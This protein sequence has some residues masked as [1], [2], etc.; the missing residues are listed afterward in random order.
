MVRNKKQ[1]ISVILSFV[2]V[3]GIEAKDPIASIPFSA[4]KVNWGLKFGNTGDNFYHVFIEPDT[5]Y[6]GGLN[7]MSEDLRPCIYWPMALKTLNISDAPNINDNTLI[8]DVLEHQENIEEL[9]LTQVSIS[10]K[11][12]L[13]I[14]KL[15][16]LKRLHL[17]KINFVTWLGIYHLVQNEKIL[18]TLEELTI[19]G[20][21][22]G[23]SGNQSDYT[24]DQGNKI[25]EIYYEY[26]GLAILNKFKNLRRLIIRGDTSF[27][28][29]GN[30]GR[31]M[32]KSLSHLNKLQELTLP[33]GEIDDSMLKDLV[34]L[35]KLQYLNIADTMITD[36]GM[37]LILK[38]KSLDRLNIKNTQIS[39]KGIKILEKHPSLKWINIS[40]GAISKNYCENYNKISKAKGNGFILDIYESSLP[41]IQQP[42][43]EGK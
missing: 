22:F 6:L 43:P 16:H 32:I 38:L 21:F 14:A 11:T 29:Q 12:M 1:W 7:L 40:Y 42:K 3:I 33:G 39:P 41:L 35:S 5:I 31:E 15:Q 17:I 24:Y 27:V 34:R 23:Y 25:S 13:R 20:D 26:K 28:T 4:T 9:V 8:I 30:F 19:H 37:K 10:D 18:E 36:E 2:L